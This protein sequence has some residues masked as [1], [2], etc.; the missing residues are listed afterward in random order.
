VCRR[1]AAVVVRPTEPAPSTATVPPSGTPAASAAWTAQAAGSTITP[2]SSE[3]ESGTAC[4]CERW[5]TI[6]V[7]HPPPVSAQN[8][9]WRPGSSRPNATRSQLP[10]C[11]RAQAGH[12]GS[13]PRAAQPSTGSITTRVPSSRSP[14]TSWPGMNGNDT[15]GSK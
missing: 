7:D 2:A 11:P 15:I 4:S 6:D 14:T 13:M 10:R 1:S 8:P 9:L 5:A 3:N 12:G